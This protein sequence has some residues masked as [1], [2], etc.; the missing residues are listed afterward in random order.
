M[1]TAR[2]C[3]VTGLRLISGSSSYGY[4]VGRNDYSALSGAPRDADTLTKD[5]EF[6]G[7]SLEAYIEEV[8]RDWSERDFMGLGAVPAGWRYDRGLIPSAFARV[9]DATRSSSTSQ[10]MH[11]ADTAIVRR[12]ATACTPHATGPEGQT[13]LR[14][15]R[16]A[17]LPSV[18]ASDASTYRMATCGSW[19]L[20]RSLLW[21]MVLGTRSTLG[22]SWCAASR[23]QSLKPCRTTQASV[24]RASFVSR[25]RVRRSPGKLVNPNLS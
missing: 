21:P 9:T 24:A 1:T 18:R 14:R 19:L 5:A 2:T 20:S 16:G 8:T 13:P 4:H 3:S 7:L 23:L 15:I 10:R 25:Y 17:G 12:A 6:A 22:T 11:R